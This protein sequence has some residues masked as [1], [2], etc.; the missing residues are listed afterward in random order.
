MYIHVHNINLLMCVCV[1]VC[2][3]VYAIFVCVCV[4]ARFSGGCAEEDACPLSL[5]LS[6]SRSL[7]RSLSL[8][9]S[10]SLTLH[11]HTC[12]YICKVFW[13][14]CRGSMS[15]LRH[16]KTCAHRQTMRRWANCGLKS[17]SSSQ[18]RFHALD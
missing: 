13:R 5:S 14:K 9:L 8:S 18:R 4:Y 1:C 10:L 2:V 11:T 17:T 12:V 15:Y 6:L 7:S 3:Y 16:T